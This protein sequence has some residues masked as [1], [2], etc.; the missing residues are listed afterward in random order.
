MQVKYLLVALNWNEQTEYLNILADPSKDPLL[1]SG[2]VTDMTPNEQGSW[3]NLVDLMNSFGFF[4]RHDHH[5]AVA[6]MQSQIA[7]FN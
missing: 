6:E 2:R 5:H 4:I 3:K 1:F 7:E